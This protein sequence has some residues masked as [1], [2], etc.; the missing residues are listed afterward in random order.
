MNSWA[1]PAACPSLAAKKVV[2]PT[3]VKSVGE[4]LAPPGLMSFSRLSVRG[5]GGAGG[6]MST[7]GSCP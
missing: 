7:Q 4:E 5:G 3:A 6:G 2:A 1:V